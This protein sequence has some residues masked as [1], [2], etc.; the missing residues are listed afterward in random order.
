MNI[1]YLP[2][3]ADIR[4]FI[5]AASLSLLLIQG[6]KGMAEILVEKGCYENMEFTVRETISLDAT[7]TT[8]L[9]IDFLSEALS[10]S[11]VHRAIFCHLDIIELS[12]RNIHAELSG[13]DV[14]TYD[15]EIKAV[16]YHEA[17]VI[18]D[19]HGNWQTTIVFDI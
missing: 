8:C 14:H 15:E 16:T 1:K 7:D 9:L 12:D 19:E 4:M 11:Y 5:E 10:L 13:G 3:T 2:H 18:Q 17:A 6:L